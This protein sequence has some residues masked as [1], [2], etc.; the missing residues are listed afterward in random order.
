MKNSIQ[1]ATPADIPALVALLNQAYRG[2][3][4]RQGWTHEADL[5]QG[6]IRTDEA[7]LAAIFEAENE[8]MLKCENE[9]GDLIGC[10]HSIKTGS[11]LFLGKLAVRPDQQGRG[12][13]KLFL[14]AAENYARAQD[15]DT[16]FMWVITERTELNEWYFRHG[17]QPTGER[18]AFQVDARYGVPV[19][20]LEFMMLEKRLEDRI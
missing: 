1:P 9:S 12:I 17:Y 20:P 8:A 10:V 18:K 11:R 5:L 16:I 13:G 6:D 3:A 2:E 4:S 14:K 19:H 15:C 7:E